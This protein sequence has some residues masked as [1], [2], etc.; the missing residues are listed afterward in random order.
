MIIQYERIFTD[1]EPEYSM[2]EQ[3][4]ATIKFLN[5]LERFGIYSNK[6]HETTLSTLFGNEMTHVVSINEPML[7]LVDGLAVEVL[8][9]SG[10]YRLIISHMT[11]G[12]HSIGLKPL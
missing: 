1:G 5:T 6:S 4:S 11:M 12:L 10:H 7:L 9:K 2:I 8:H 3:P